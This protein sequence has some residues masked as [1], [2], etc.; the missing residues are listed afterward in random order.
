M[1]T[2]IRVGT[3]VGTLPR[4]GCPKE[5]PLSDPKD[6]LSGRA[7]VIA[8]WVGCVSSGVELGGGNLPADQLS[9]HF[10]KSGNLSPRPHI[11]L[12]R[13]LGP[14]IGPF[15]GRRTQAVGVVS[16]WKLELL[17]PTEL[18]CQSKDRSPNCTPTH[19]RDKGLRTELELCSM[20]AVPDCGGGAP[21]IAARG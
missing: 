20:G 17:G 7:A 21:L 16:L 10:Q 4:H 5:R 9:A 18:R 6:A 15:V 19:S 3:I 13:G 2:R 8:A 12:L 11:C 1:G 14:A